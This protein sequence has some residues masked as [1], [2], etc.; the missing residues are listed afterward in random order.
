MAAVILDEY[1]PHGDNI[2]VIPTGGGDTP[3]HF[4]GLTNP[5]INQGTEFD[6]TEGVRALDKD[7]NEV[8]Y[9]VEPDEID[10]CEKGNH[11]LTYTAGETTATRIVTVQT[12]DDPTISGADTITVQVNEEFDPL[13]GVTAVDGNGNTLEVTVEGGDSRRIVVDVRNYTVPNPN[14]TPKAGTWDWEQTYH[15]EATGVYADGVSCEVTRVYTEN[16]T[17][18]VLVLDNGVEVHLY[19]R[20]DTFYSYITAVQAPNEVTFEHL[21]VYYEDWE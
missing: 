7:G 15:C 4:E 13:D 11:T 3:P 6:P 2:V 8:A 18:I 5:T 12:I 19:E 21:V 10:T 20:D 16:D 1:N 9:T 17:N 14:F